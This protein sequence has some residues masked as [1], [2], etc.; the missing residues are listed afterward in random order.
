MK[1]RT[2]AGRV[3]LTQSGLTLI[4]LAAVIAGTSATARALLDQ[5]TDG[6][7]KE[8]ITRVAELTEHVTPAQLD[9]PKIEEEIDDARPSEVR[10]ELGDAR[11]HVLASSG[12]GPSFAARALGCRD[13]DEYRVCTARAGRF[14]VI[15]AVDRSADLDAKRR[16][17]VTLIV[18]AAAIGAMVSIVSRRV[19][20]RTLAP[21]TDLAS[22]IAQIAPG[23]GAR[24]RTASPFAELEG[25][26]VRFD[27][28]IA[29]YDEALARERR[30]TAQAS[31]ELRTPLAVARA[32]VEA[33]S[34]PSELATGRTRALTALDRLSELV[35]AILWFA[36]AETRLDDARVG[37]VNIADVVRAQLIER[38][39]LHE[40][41]SIASALPDEALIRGD[42]E[43]LGRV[44]ANLLDNAI[45]YGDGKHLRV[46]AERERGV[47]CIRVANSGTPPSSELA[48]HIFEPFYR[49][50][51]HAPDT[52]GFGLGLPFARA[53]ARAHGGNIELMR[54]AAT[55]VTEFDL[56]LPLV[57]WGDHALDPETRGG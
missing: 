11:G 35:E 4:A 33:L 27:D 43:L 8:M 18:V 17:L 48:E 49:G 46:S 1:R 24:I 7:L 3:S 51:R 39:R 12:P 2:L 31:H 40:W 29:R 10:V 19:A 55:H 41:Q 36:K 52:P 30:L 23:A 53:V 25:L 13:H 16:A 34:D 50:A 21:L 32:E 37:I 38:E 26:R 42:E 56:T 9:A 57:D 20:R 45:K 14:I 44:I 28:L 15:A 22:R 5:Q 47:L 54:S 6:A